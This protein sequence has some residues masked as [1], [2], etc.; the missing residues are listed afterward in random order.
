VVPALKSTV[1]VGTPVPTT[2]ATVAEYVRVCAVAPA[3]WTDNAVVVAP[4]A[5]DV[6]PE[7]VVKLGSPE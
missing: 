6:V 5:N 3:E 4:T 2:G 1:P 7:D